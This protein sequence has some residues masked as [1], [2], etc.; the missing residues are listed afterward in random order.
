MTTILKT[1]KAAGLTSLSSALLI[2]A[3]QAVWTGLTGN[4]AY[5]NPS[6]DLA[7]LKAAIDGYTAALAAARD[8]GKTALLER[9]AKRAALIRVLRNLASYVEHNCQDNMSTF[10]S[11]GFTPR[12]P[13]S[14]AQQPMS[15]ASILWVDCG[16]NSGQ[17]QVAVKPMPKQARS[18]ELRY[19]TLDE[20][21]VLGPWTTVTLVK[22]KPAAVVS[23]LTPRM[24][25]AFQVR[26]LG[27]LGFTDWC[28]S[29]TRICI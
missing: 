20:G 29:M 3:A 5:P 6:V 24:N 10:T 23:G 28:D 27:V 22:A 1:I 19:A 9:D 12:L 21:G 7:V 26:A 13:G 14:R 25:Y 4:A 11:S 18:F 16:A 2:A 17:M 8:G 15:P